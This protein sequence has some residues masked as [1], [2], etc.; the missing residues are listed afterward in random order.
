MIKAIDKKYYINVKHISRPIIEKLIAEQNIDKYAAAD[1]LY[2]SK[3]FSGLSDKTTELYQ[4]QWT[5]I[6]DMLKIELNL[7]ACRPSEL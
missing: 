4:K 1:M 2:N 5:E 6:Y 7:K 3:I